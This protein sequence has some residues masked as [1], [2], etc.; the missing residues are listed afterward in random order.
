MRKSLGVAATADL[1]FTCLGA[2]FFI[3]T[4]IGESCVGNGME[5]NIWTAKCQQSQGPFGCEG[6]TEIA[7][8]WATRPENHAAVP[9]NYCA[10]ERKARCRTSLTA[11]GV[12]SRRGPNTVLN[13][14]GT[15]ANSRIPTHPKSAAYASAVFDFMDSPTPRLLHSCCS[16][17]YS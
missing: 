15:T 16:H 3:S 1:T 14:P 17:P 8:G 6:T 9:L 5:R 7:R 4:S 2:G 10:G 11:T 12:S 13:G